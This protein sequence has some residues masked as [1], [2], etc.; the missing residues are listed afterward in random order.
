MFPFIRTAVKPFDFLTQL[1]RIRSG[2]RI[3]EQNHF[4]DLAVSVFIE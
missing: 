3:K 4:D 1:F 2:N